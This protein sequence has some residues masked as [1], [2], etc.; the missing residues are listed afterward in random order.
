[1]L[2]TYRVLETYSFLRKIDGMSWLEAHLD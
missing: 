1:V 2:R